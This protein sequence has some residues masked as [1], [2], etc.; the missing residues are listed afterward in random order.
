MGLQFNTVRM[1]RATF[2]GLQMQSPRVFT[3]TLERWVRN[4]VLQV[5]TLTDLVNAR[6]GQQNTL[7]F[8]TSSGSV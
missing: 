1:I 4:T 3:V 5:K 2:K 8:L 7:A 6:G